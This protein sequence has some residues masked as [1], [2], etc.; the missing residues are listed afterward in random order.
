M[1]HIKVTNISGVSQ[2]L[3]DGSEYV[4][5][6]HGRKY[7]ADTAADLDANGGNG[8]GVFLN[9]INPGNT[10]RGVIRPTCPRVTRR[11]GPSCTIPR[12]RAA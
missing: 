3:D 7:D 12:S 11:S 6:G 2:T 4:F 8:G 10:V 1:L 9:D 5:D